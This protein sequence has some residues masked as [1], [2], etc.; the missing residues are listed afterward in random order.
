LERRRLEQ[1]ARAAELEAQ[2][3]AR[4]EAEK[5]EAAGKVE[6]ERRTTESQE[7]AELRARLTEERER[8]T[9]FERKMKWLMWTRHGQA[10][11]DVLDKYGELVGKMRE[12]HVR[13]ATHLEDRQVAA[14]MELRASL[15]QAERSVQ[16]RLRHMEAYCD[17]LGRASYGPPRVVT[18]RDLRELGQQY[19]VRDDLERLHQSKINVMRDK[20][21]KQ[22]EQLL[23]RQLEEEE[24]L[25]ARQDVELDTLEASF[26]AEEVNFLQAF[27]ARRERVLQRWR[28]AEEIEREKLHQRTKLRYAPLSLPEWP[29]PKDSPESVLESVTE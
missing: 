18:E 4:E 27:K 13:T 25:I 19:N 17:G 22:M 24:K 28:L 11:L 6:A 1:E 23:A 9:T 8:F 7:L 10:K 29:E 21:A 12:R 16:I 3:A 15:K 14:E 2:K 26:S 20:Q 5:L